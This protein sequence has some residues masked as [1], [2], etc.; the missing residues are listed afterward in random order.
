LRGYP[1]FEILNSVIRLDAIFVMDVFIGKQ[2]PTEMIGHD[3]AML[4]APAKGPTVPTAA[5]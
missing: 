5:A 3:D 4:E 2:W 1:Q